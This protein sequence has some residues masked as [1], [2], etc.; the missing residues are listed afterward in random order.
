M[1]RRMVR[2]S[3]RRG[4]WLKKA[5]L[6]FASLLMLGALPFAGVSQAAPV[7]NPANGHY[8]QAVAVP[9]GITWYSAK[10]AAES[11]TYGVQGHLA[12]I[13]SA[14]ENDFIASSF[15]S[16]FNPNGGLYWV[17][18]YQDLGAS[19]Y[20]EP[21]G[22]W[23]WVT[24]EAWSYTNWSPGEPN[25]F[26]GYQSENHL[27]L[28]GF[29]GAFWNDLPGGNSQPGYV[30]EYDTPSYNVCSVLYDQ[31]KSHKLGSTVPIKIQ[32]CDGSG[33]NISSPGL[34]VTATG[35]AKLDP[36]ASAT[37]DDS[38]SANS[39]D[40]NFRY[41]VT[42]AGYIFNLSTKGLTTGTWVLSFTV[43]AD[44]TVKTVQFDIK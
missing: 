15:P 24:G 26:S 10:A 31:T 29:Y 17:G 8:Y 6:L 39:P 7:L 32:V 12:S 34:P 44:P 27:V 22:G 37:V 14:A 2:R 43:G 4:P 25:D 11:S 28:W 38:G 33:V 19:D 36:T 21:A 9:G 23:R 20:W 18:G 41:D 16:A 13:T 1:K 42:L 3:D 40:N 5:F 35:L 30:V